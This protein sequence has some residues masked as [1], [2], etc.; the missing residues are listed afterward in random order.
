[1]ATER[2]PFVIA[3]RLVSAALT[4]AMGAIH[5]YLWDDGGYRDLETIGVLFL[6]NA[7]GSALLTLALLAFPT[8]YVGV[9]AALGALFTAGTLAALVISLTIGLFGFLESL[10]GELVW[11]TIAVESAGVVALTALTLLAYDL[12]HRG[13]KTRPQA[14]E[15][16]HRG[17]SGA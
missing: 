1:M 10:D 14:P 3:L 13:R 8:R 12:R 6:L 2:A 9:P 5:L 4:A 11:P 7:I 15:G 16:L 17:P